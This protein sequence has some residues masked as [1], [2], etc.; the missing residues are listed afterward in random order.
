MLALST[1]PLA[2]CRSWLGPRLGGMLQRLPLCTQASSEAPS[3]PVGLTSDMRPPNDASRKWVKVDTMGRAYATGRRKT[4]VARV[5]VWP[6]ADGNA[7]SIRLNKQS[8]SSFLGGHWVQRHTILAPFFE[9]GTAGKYNV[10][11]TVRGGG[12]SGVNGPRCVIILWVMDL[13]LRVFLCA[14]GRA[15]RG[16]SSWYSNCSTR[17]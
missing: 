11:A 14:C 12:T 6:C 17:P 3:A 10:L 4:A 2:N 13:R 16:S 9:T 5:W 7:P 15:C 1:R 8:L